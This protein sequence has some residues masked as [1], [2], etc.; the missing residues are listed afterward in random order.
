MT[1]DLPLSRADL[2]LNALSDLLL[3]DLLVK[4]NGG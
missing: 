3:T 4:A 2:R 1:R